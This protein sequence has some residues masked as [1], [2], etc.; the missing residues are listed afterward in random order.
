M[1]CVLD[2]K[3]INRKWV[4]LKINIRRRLKISM[5]AFGFLSLIF[6]VS[7]IF[8]NRTSK[9]I[10]AYTDRLLLS[11]QTHNKNVIINE[12][13]KGYKGRENLFLKK[14]D[15]IDSIFGNINTF[16]PISISKNFNGSYDVSYRVIFQKA[17]KCRAYFKVKKDSDAGF[18]LGEI[19][20]MEPNKNK[21]DDAFGRYLS[22]RPLRDSL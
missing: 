11:I 4:L 7:F 5:Y 15:A 13:G 14:L 18:K 3:Q 21:N 22:V 1:F 16:E 6:A 20:I 10:I 17:G 12:Y 9:P 19:D 8:I 2:V